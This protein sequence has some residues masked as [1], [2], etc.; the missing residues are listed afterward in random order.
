MRAPL[1]HDEA[2]HEFLDQFVVRRKDVFS[3][4]VQ[5]AVSGLRTAKK[6]RAEY[7]ICVLRD[8]C[9]P[10]VEELFDG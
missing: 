8:L 4:L 2:P 6:V 9:N 10:V 5:I 1:R 3:R 7:K